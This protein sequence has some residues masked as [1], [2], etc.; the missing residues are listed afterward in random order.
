MEKKYQRPMATH[1][2][3]NEETS[4]ELI[5][6][7]EDV[8]IKDFELEYQAKVSARKRKKPYMMTKKLLYCISYYQQSY[9][10]IE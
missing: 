10:K 1:D 5:G 6:R 8:Y 4:F 9:M 7:G 3:E 2:V